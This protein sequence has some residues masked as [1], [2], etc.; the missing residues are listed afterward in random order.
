MTDQIAFNVGHAIG[1]YG[2]IYL[3][4]AVIVGVVL[5]TMWWLNRCDRD[6]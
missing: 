6:D 3:G 4:L 2:P 1:F 5:L